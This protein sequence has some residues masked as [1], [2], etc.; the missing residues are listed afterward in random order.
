MKGGANGKFGEVDS[1]KIAAPG[2]SCSGLEAYSANYHDERI[3]T[4]V[5]LNSGV[6]DKEKVCLLSELKAPVAQ[7]IE[8]PKDVAYSNLSASICR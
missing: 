3:K 2:Q 6:I 7:F 8:G 4:T 1:T 5:L